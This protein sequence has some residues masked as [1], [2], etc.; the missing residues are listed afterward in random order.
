M[1]NRLVSLFGAVDFP[2]LSM[3][4]SLDFEIQVEV[5]KCEIY[6]TVFGL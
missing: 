4:T 6:D 3:L 5:P 1:A 2:D